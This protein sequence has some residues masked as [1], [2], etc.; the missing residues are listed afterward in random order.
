MNFD[1]I[2]NFCELNRDANLN[3]CKL[4]GEITVA[5]C[6]R[7][8]PSTNVILVEI[9]R[10]FV[11]LHSNVSFTSMV[12]GQITPVCAFSRSIYSIDRENAHKGEFDIKRDSG[13]IH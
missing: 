12:R 2:K 6:G 5:Q 3:G 10:V 11:L 4:N 13:H 9:K 1:F 7:K 8:Q